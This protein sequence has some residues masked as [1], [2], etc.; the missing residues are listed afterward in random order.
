MD[1]AQAAHT[2]DM[3]WRA[4][5]SHQGQGDGEQA[6]HLRDEEMENRRGA[7]GGQ[8]SRNHSR[9][10]VAERKSV[11]TSMTVRPSFWLY[12]CCV[13][14]HSMTRVPKF[15]CLCVCMSS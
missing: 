8:A 11:S 2:R 3:E 1:D 5:C 12:L 4:G 6:T 9:G 13:F 15:V 10:G 7:R 14:H